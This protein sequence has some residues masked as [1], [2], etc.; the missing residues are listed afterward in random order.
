MTMQAGSIANRAPK[1][2]SAFFS[3]TLFISA[4]LMFAVQ[5]MIGK[6]ML[7]LVGGTPSAWLIAMAFFQLVLL[8]GYAFA[9]GLSYLPPRK[10]VI[11]VCA[12]LLLGL[13][14][15]P[16]GFGANSN[17]ET[18]GPAKVFFALLS[19][20]FLPFFALSTVSS[21]LQRLFSSQGKLADPYF[22]F[23][24]SNFG[25]F[26][27][28][29]LYPFWL[30]RYYG[31]LIQSAGW[32]IV[33]IALI[34]LCVGCL[35]L[36]QK[37]R[38]SVEERQETA[39]PVS[40]GQ[41]G[42]WVLLAF[43]PSSLMLGITAYITVEQGSIPLFWVIPLALYLF[44]FVVAF[45]RHQIIKPSLVS[46][47]QP[48]TL[49]FIFFIFLEKPFIT[50]MGS[51]HLIY[52]ALAFFFSALLCHLKL[53]SERPPPGRLTEYY[54]WIA[55]GGAL[56]GSF[57]AFL[58]PILF[59]LP[60]E[61]MLVILASCWLHPGLFKASSRTAS[62]IRAIAVVLAVLA[63]VIWSVF[64]PN[65]PRFRDS[66][67]FQDPMPLG[68]ALAGVFCYGLFYWYV[69]AKSSDSGRSSSKGL[70][71]FAGLLALVA[72]A[73]IA[74]H[75]KA[76][77]N[78]LIGDTTLLIMFF[79]LSVVSLWPRVFMVI[80]PILALTAFF[81]QA[82]PE[83][84]EAKRNF[85][86]V[87]R[88]FEK[89]DTNVTVRLLFHGSTLHDDQQ[90]APA[91]DIIPHSYYD[92]VGPLGDIFRTVKPE[93]V[94]VIG[95]G[96]GS[97]ACYQ[98]LGQQ[99]TFYDIDPDVVEIAKNQFHYLNNCGMPKIVIG[100]GRRALMAATD[101]H[102]D[103]LTLDAFTSDMVP[104]HMLTREAFQLYLERL[105]PKGVIAIHISSRYYDLRQPLADIAHALGLYGMCMD[106][107]AEKMHPLS[108]DSRWV[109]LSRSPDVMT[110]FHQHKWRD[111]PL[112]DG[113]LWTDD[114]SSVLPVLIYSSML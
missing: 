83:I 54:L 103:L 12:V 47:L 44:T 43:V 91:V 84:V 95:L 58:A 93:S 36:S 101:A 22:L 41:R 26:C 70:F 57:N 102:Y 27:G 67:L 74:I 96:A 63:S 76:Y 34:G 78:S 75:L 110:T 69:K 31:L 65:N 59:P 88:V 55:V 77:K 114:Y 5:P 35:L 108:F 28:L 2:R 24:A 17:I 29:L 81:V 7:P 56:G 90:T 39:P 94:G 109:V 87:W 10:H 33:Y 18:P 113:D 72:V 40:W 111:L 99:F 14:M 86:G 105:K 6:M 68:F 23:A 9:H 85:F 82:A 92:P 64:G 62:C 66:Q 16:L 20:V 104:I 79:S 112:P 11:A 37:S 46:A 45:A 32:Q 1:L 97:M 25:S 107:S 42:R 49:A 53:A 4:G 100:D 106:S 19:H 51:E 61:F 8:A 52:P 89:T 21:S 60:I 3:F 71:F 30:E 15:L 73:A 13:V 98:N 80:A 48:L 38:E 50:E